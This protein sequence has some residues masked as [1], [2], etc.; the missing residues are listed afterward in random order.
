[1]IAQGGTRQDEAFTL[2]E[3]LVVVAIIGV[4]ASLLLPAMSKVQEAGRGTA[5]LGNLRQVGIALQLYVQDNQNRMPSIRDRLIDTNNVAI[6]NSPAG[7]AFPTIDQAL[8]H[9][10]GNVAVLRCP[11]DRKQ[12]FEQTGSSYSW[13]NLLNGQDADHL[14]LMGLDFNPHQIPVVYDKES[15]HKA[16]GPKKGI[17]FLYADG[18]IKNLLAL[19]GTTGVSSAP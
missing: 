11:S 1:M 14:Q 4:L 10:L 18:H 19:E 6:T 12:L 9:H 17:N 8:G 13:N 5:C 2:I 15:F 3:L 16:R 7:Q